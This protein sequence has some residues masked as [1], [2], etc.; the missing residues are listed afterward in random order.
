MILSGQMKREEALSK[1]K[2]EPIS[3]LELKKEISFV[4]NKLDISKSE[5][6]EFF[7]LRK[8]SFR[9]YKSNYFIINFFTKVLNTL[10]I[11]KRIF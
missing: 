4:C 1:I 6:E 8:K 11:E 7:N 5:L 9:D 2:E 3:D 10:N